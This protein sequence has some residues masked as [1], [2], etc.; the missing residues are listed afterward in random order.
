LLVTAQERDGLYIISSKSAKAQHESAMLAHTKET[1][2]EW[3]QRY[4]HLG[5]SNMA[6]LVKEN[7]VKGINVSAE[8]FLAANKEACETCAKSKQARQPFNSSDTEIDEPLALVH[9]DLCGPMKQQ[10][11]GGKLYLATFLDDYS[12]LSV[13][14]LL[15]HKSEMA[16]AMKEVFTMLENQSGSRVKALRTDNGTEYV[17]AAVSGYLKN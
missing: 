6:R 8:K 11:L 4:A 2:Q 16:A 9:S 13:I 1:A 12:G 7:M 3:H 5:Y 14:K 17:N 15:K 10:S